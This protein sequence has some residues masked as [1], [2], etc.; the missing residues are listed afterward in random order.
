MKSNIADYRCIKRL[1]IGICTE[2]VR[3]LL[4]AA[5]GDSIM[6]EMRKAMKKLTT[7]LTIALV[8]V[9]AL[10]VFAACGKE[11]NRVFAVNSANEEYGLWWYGPDGSDD[12]V[13][14]ASAT[15]SKDYYD[16]S[17]PTIIYSHGLKMGEPLELLQPVEKAVNMVKDKEGIDLT[18]EY[19]S[20]AKQLKDLGYNVGYFRWTKYAGFFTGNE[21]MIWMPQ[22]SSSAL[23]EIKK[24]LPGVSLAGEFAREFVTSMR[25][26][27]GQPVYFMGHSFGAQM[28]TA[29][30]RTLYGMAE[31]GM[32]ENTNILPG[33][34]LL[35]DPYIPGGSMYA[36]SGTADTI[37]LD[38]T[39]KDTADAMAESLAYLNQK[40]VASDLYCAMPTAYHLYGDNRPEI[41]ETLWENTNYIVMT[42]LNELYGEIGDVHNV[43][44]DWVWC[45]FLASAKG[46]LGD[47]VYPLPTADPSEARE[48]GKYSATSAFNFPDVTIVGLEQSA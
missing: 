13:V 38:L 25:G 11:D 34:L 19:G 16:P 26:Y 40:G 8:A 42:E 32:L 6:E 21:Q 33:R 2:N 44:R 28:V 39:G 46:E 37:N 31:M 48:Y 23:I 1:P 17:K 41:D 24:E 35:A 9:L 14:R 12:T 5:H 30:A 18:A 4:T 15:L 7:V 20:Y 45:E 47:D 22:T 36:L 43:A 29:A 27:Q 10:G 3:S